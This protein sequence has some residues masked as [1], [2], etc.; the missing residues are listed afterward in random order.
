MSLP[1]PWLAAALVGVGRAPLPD[2]AGLPPPLAE[3]RAALQGRPPAD[4]LLL[5]AGAAA[6]YDDLGRLPPRAPATEWYLPAL[7]DEGDRP[8]CSPAAA[9]FLECMFSQQHVDLLPELLALL[10]EA[11]QRI[12]APLLPHALAHG[13]RV[14]RVRPLLLPVLGE[15]GRWLGAV[16]P[17]WRYA[18]VEL[19]DWRSLRTAWE[20]DPAGRVPLATLTRRR[21]PALA[22]RLVETTW[23]GETAVVRR[24]LL[25]VL[26]SGLSAA[27]EPFLE[28]A[29]DD[30]DLQV[31]HKAAALLAGLPNSR[32]TAR[33]ID[34]AGDILALSGGH[35]TPRFPAAV[36][37]ALV[38]DGVTR[39]VG[40]G[41]SASERTRLLMQTVGVI[42]PWH[43]EERL[44]ATPAA[45]VAAARAGRW[46]RTLLSALTAATARHPDRRWTAALLEGEA[47]S[48][49]HGALIGLLS[50]A[51]MGA[52]LAAAGAAED[53]AAVVVLLRRWP[54]AWPEDDARA[55]IRFLAAA[56]A[57]PADTRHGPTLRFLMRGFARRC[58]PALAEFAAAA[59]AGPAGTPAWKTSVSLFV[60]TLQ[61]RRE[62][63][64]AVRG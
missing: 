32:L 58:P 16:N 2:D 64:L 53:E 4:V 50:P 57:R 22:A 20:R 55:L 6:L 43:W 37:D 62:M 38:R 25:A 28:R 40:S 34:A 21:A 42:P 14:A 3:L 8:A 36:S 30:L 54:H 23:R 9:L 45:L 56:A 52:R 19:D 49:S 31:R 17:A 44:A 35:L 5:L 51:E 27:D 61:L 48:E 1:R 41:A 60:S 26:E 18:A 24:E 13:A 59:L 46:P 10:D 7:R 33:M 11:G 47:L 29:L 15:R 39:P 63:E 12:A